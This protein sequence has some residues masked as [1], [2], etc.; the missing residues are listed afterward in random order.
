[1]SLVDSQPE[2]RSWW[3][4]LE[5]LADTPRFR[6]FLE[7]EFP[8]QA[9]PQG[10]NR[11]R[12][13]Q[14]M[15]ASF[16]LAGMAGC[17]Q[18]QSIL[19]FAERPEDYTP[20][21]PRRFATAMPLGES[22]LRLMVTVVDG[23]PIKIEGN[24]T[25]E[26]NKAED[27]AENKEHP[28]SHGAADALAQAA[29]LSLYD[30]DRSG[31]VLHRE[32]QA[33]VAGTWSDFA[34][35][36]R[37]RFAEVHKSEGEGFRVLGEAGSSPTLKSL[38]NDLLAAF[39]KAK[40]FDFDPL[41]DDNQRAGSIL[42]F[43]KPV[44][45]HFS[46][47]EARV[48]LCLDSD[49]LGSHPAA[50][51]HSRDFAAGREVPGPMNRLY[52]VESSFTLTGA[53]ADHRLPLKSSHIPAFLC[54][55]EREIAAANRA[56]TEA[57]VGSEDSRKPGRKGQFA[58][59]VWKDLLK[60]R[61]RSVVSI[62]PAQPPEAHAAVH[63]INSLLG[64]VG[65]TVTY[66]RVPH[67]QRFSHVEAIKTLVGEIDAGSVTTLLILGGNPVYD[68]P[69]DLAFADA[70]GKVETSIHLS[71]YYDETSRQSTWHLPRA[72]FLES[73][74]DARSYDG[75]YSVIQPMIA[76]L[77][78]GRSPIEVLAMILAVVSDEEERLGEPEQLVRRTFREIADDSAWRRT[79]RDGL[80][81]GSKWPDEEVPEA[82]GPELGSEDLSDDPGEE[83]ANAEQI[84]VIFQQDASVHD[85]RFA[86]NGWL[87][88]LPDPMTKLTWGNAALLSPATA[89]QL[90]VEHEMT[91][92]VEVAGRQ[93]EL[94]V[95]LMPGQAAGS[96]TLQLGYGR[97]AAGHVGGDDAKGVAAVGV[98]V[99]PLRS[100]QAMSIVHDAKIKAAGGRVRLA[101]TQDHHAIDAVGRE[102]KNQRLGDLVRQ[103]T[104]K[105]YQEHPDFARHAVHHP[106][107]ESLWKEAQFEG[108]RWGMSIDLSKCTGCGACV[109]A[110][111]AENNVPVVGKEQVLLGR[112]MHWL[113]ID[114]YFQGEADD[115]DPQVAQQPLP[116]QQCELAPCEQVCPV[117][118][119]VHSQEGLNDMVY[120]RCVG[121]RY[122]ANN[123]P[124]KVRR[125][126]YFYFHKDLEDEAN[127][128]AKMKYNPQVTVRSR[129][130]MEKCTYCVQRIQAAKI[131]A[132]NR[133][134]AVEDGKIQT[135]CQQTC[136]TQAIV[137]G[138]LADPN[139]EVSKMH[140][141]G[142]A[143][144]MLGELNL[145]PRT[146]YLARIRNPNPELEPAGDK[147]DGDTG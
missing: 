65:R 71:P 8:E 144:A 72:H 18:Q 19:P 88:E 97:T 138:D 16:A 96:V 24:G 77:F 12:W 41:G 112:E 73:W 22:A 104:L 30:P 13:M 53:A 142:R 48:I 45:T 139:S 51:L 89:G 99:Y 63:R 106:P 52:A 130:V 38:R 145:K 140:S 105:H 20:G 7:S 110:C 78:D 4:S 120:N 100:T 103:S 84:E 133:G 62:G 91:V 36:C 111:Q 131:E 49:L 95:Y 31:T 121:T 33:A 69:A 108:H 114:R 127:E 29:I 128:V 107:L 98:D 80:L 79:V 81:A 70:L 44:R 134:D 137:F 68:A 25:V 117:A 34:E 61:G 87:Q 116:C 113:R 74:G 6:S 129:G 119:T 58:R 21:K 54:A 39:P 136:P 46:L 147:H 17:W 126:N 15:G 102:G 10:V 124:Y 57:A 35:Q 125:F 55:L 94:P 118:A 83:T 40:W 42:A 86:N 109:V 146:F 37:T 75:T 50:L 1:M 141:S 47:Q 59:A 90:G 60:H 11:R 122:C 27:E 85:G 64:N 9:D 23:R 123:C 115:P 56:D 66:T 28:Q 143:Y 101:S 135:A 76:P 5:Q 14:V 26:G 32:G 132:R 82:G 92:V 93:A 3:R 67:P 43:G 2:S